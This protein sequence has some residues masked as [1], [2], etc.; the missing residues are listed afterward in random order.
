MTASASRSGRI[1]LCRIQFVCDYRTSGTGE[2][3][4]AWSWSV[5][6]KANPIATC[7]MAKNAQRR[8]VLLICNRLT[9]SDV[10][11]HP[12]LSY[13]Q[14]FSLRF[15]IRLKRLGLPVK[16]KAKIFSFCGFRHSVGEKCPVCVALATK[17]DVRSR[18]RS[19]QLYSL[20]LRPGGRLDIQSG[21]STVQGQSLRQHVLFTDSNA[22]IL[23]TSRN[24]LEET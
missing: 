16:R 14:Y 3:V 7:S 24:A 2:R 17:S 1:L 10:P 13:Q 9:Q 12:P 11:E 23:Q 18:R 15:P 19:T 8:K 20:G 21:I 4:G 6:A 5:A 22:H